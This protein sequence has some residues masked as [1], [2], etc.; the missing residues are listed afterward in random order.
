MHEHPERVTRLLDHLTTVVR[1]LRAVAGVFLVMALAGG[2]LVFA[3]FVRAGWLWWVGLVLGAVVALPAVALW[4]FRSG[5]IPALGLPDLLRD[6]PT[7]VEEVKDDLAP[8][9]AALDGVVDKPK[10]PW[11][12]FHS[13][14]GTK[15]AIDAFNDSVYGQLVGNAAVLHPAA[16]MAGAT[17]TVFAT[18]SLLLG[19]LLFFLAGQ[20]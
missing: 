12:M 16:L 11:A 13:I 17:S 7:S 2:V 1:G 18:G 20:F 19:V 5:L 10:S 4:R 14:R 15:S 8:M 6:L 9:A 3:G